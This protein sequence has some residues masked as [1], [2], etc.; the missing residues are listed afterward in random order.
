MDTKQLIDSN[1]HITITTKFKLHQKVY[2]PRITAQGN[3]W[4]LENITS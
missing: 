1:G 2:H 4:I 3:Y